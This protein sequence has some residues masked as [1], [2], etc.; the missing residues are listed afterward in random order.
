MKVSEVVRIQLNLKNKSFRTER[1]SHISLNFSKI[2]RNRQLH[3]LFSSK[4]R[5]LFN[6]PRMAR[7]LT[8]S[9]FKATKVS[10]ISA[11]SKLK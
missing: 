7:K 2:I 11:F 6:I 8:R 10:E 9:E 3:N 4:N 5:K 1:Q